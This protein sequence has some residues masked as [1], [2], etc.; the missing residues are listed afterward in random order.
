MKKHSKFLLLLLAAMPML[1]NA[2]KKYELK[3]PSNILKVE[4]SVDKDDVKYS[5]SHGGD[6]LIENSPISMT[7][8]N[9]TTFGKTPKLSKIKQKSVN[10]TITPPIYKKSTIKDNYNEMILDFKGD[11][12]IVFRAY[13]DGVAYRFVS[14]LKK[15]FIV[16]SEQIELP[17]PLDNTMFIAYSK[18]RKNNGVQDYHYT[19]FQNTYTHSKVSEW[20]E[21]IPAFLPL[22]IE[23]QNG[24][25]ICV[26]EADLLDYPGLHFVGQ[27]TTL[28]G[29]FPAYPNEVV[30]AVR[31]LKAEVRS[32]HPYIAKAKGKTSFPWRVFV[33]SN[34]DAELLDSD[35]VYKLANAAPECD[36]SWIKPGKVAWD[37]WNDWS[38]YGVDFEAGVNNDTYKYYIDFASKNGIEYV[39]LDEGW[40]VPGAADL[41]KVVPEIDLVELVAYAKAKN[42]DLILW[43]GYRAFDKDMD[44]VCKHY[45]AMGIKGFKIDFMDRDDQMLIDFN[46]RCAEVGLKH[47]LLIN[48]HGTSK[49]TG[50]N[51]T[52][53]NC[54]NFEGVFGLEELKWSEKGTDMVTYD[55]TF[56]FI[57][58]VAGPLDYTQG[59]MN[60]VI[61]KNYNPV[62]TEPMSQGTRCRQLALYGILESPI[63]MLCDA[64]TNYLKEQECVDFITDIPTV[65]SETKALDSKVGEYITMARRSGDTWYVSGLTNWV[66]R[67]VELDLS[68]VPDGATIELFRD[69]VNAHKIAKDY[70]R[71]VL[72]L[73]KDKK[74]TVNMASGGGFIMKVT[75]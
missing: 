60:N 40:S 68:F 32:R 65:W 15:P 75:K 7:L 30:D 14:N 46:R 25:K 11:Y 71:E 66:K 22:L 26:T 74:L 36:Y 61:M 6:M 21:N 33:V 28:K 31:G 2:Q 72:K 19:S 45:A 13:S 70:K 57:R 34:N 67:T 1:V 49:P 62:Y 54:I 52:Y 24:K 48:L 42:V 4:V 20:N 56:P 64:P 63:N 17:L 10:Q 41:F 8:T 3:D 73:S 39:I 16:E 23:C 27:G 35:M 37:W 59:A 50:L 44:A 38:I 47:K 53:P 69:G 51:R 43:A 5:V 55:V 58:M 9:G 29:I 18:G 12:S